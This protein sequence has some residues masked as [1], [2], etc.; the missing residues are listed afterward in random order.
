L[1]SLRR[2]RP[3]LDLG[4]GSTVWLCSVSAAVCL[5]IGIESDLDWERGEPELLRRRNIDGSCWHIR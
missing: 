3:Q 2:G 1:Q 4:L 5:D